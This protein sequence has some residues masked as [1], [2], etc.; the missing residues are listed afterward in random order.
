MQH[1]VHQ[2]NF[3]QISYKINPSTW[4]FSYCQRGVNIA[5]SQ[6]VLQENTWFNITE[7]NGRY[8]FSQTTLMVIRTMTLISL[9]V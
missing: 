7:V 9:P 2:K 3:P 6:G 5:P 1:E 4:R 8:K